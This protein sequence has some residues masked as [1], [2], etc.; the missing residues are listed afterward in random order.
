LVLLKLFDNADEPDL[1]LEDYLP[2]ST[3]GA[4]LIT[5]RNRDCIEYAPDSEIQVGEMSETEAVDL[6]HRVAKVHPPS[7]GTSVAIVR[8]LGMLALAV[9]QAGAY[10]FKTRQLN[11][12][13]DIF[14]KHRA[15]LLR[16]ASLR[17]RN[18]ERSTYT[19]FDLSFR[20]LP[21]KSQEFMKICSFL[22]HYR[23]PRALFEKSITN[24]F[25]PEFDIEG[26]PPMAEMETLISSLKDTFGSGWDDHVFN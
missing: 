6:L 20:L 3:S 24:G 8:E 4:V 5:T 19:A 14:R 21:E 1:R 26:Y 16:E 2:N 23:I 12:Y 10:I 22:H 25:R 17:R 7:K 13:L 11:R 18:Y 15:E 9:T